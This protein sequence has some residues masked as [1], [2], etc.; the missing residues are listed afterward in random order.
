[1]RAKL[2][3]KMGYALADQVTYSFGNMVVA[4]L[5]SRHASAREFGMYILTQRALD[6]LM[7][8]C[9]VFSW[10]P[11]TFNLPGVAKERL[12]LYDGSMVTQQMVGCVFSGLLLFAASRWASTPARGIYYGVFTPL[13]LC[14]AGILFREFTRR[15]YFARM[16]FREAFWTDV[17]TVALQIAGVGWLAF[18]HRLDVRRALEVLS[19][20]AMVV[21]FWWLKGEWNCL[22]L[23]VARE[24]GGSAAEPEAGA[25]AVWREHGVYGELAV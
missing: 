3:E 9:N 7:Q 10:G 2:G 19:L 5:F 24:L 6:V 23:A 1:M 12:A 8:L 20:A 17:V 25:V 4:A 11:Y 13:I 18:T 14:S 22:E 21:S 16:R 15:L